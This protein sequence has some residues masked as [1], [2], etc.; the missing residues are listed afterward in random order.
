MTLLSITDLSAGYG[1]VSVLHGV[2]LSVPAGRVIALVGANGAGKSTLLRTISGQIRATSG[3]IEYRGQVINDLK[4]DKIVA[5]GLVQ[6]PE[7]RRLFPS[8]TVLENLLVGASAPAAKLECAASLEK[9]FAM[10]P[11]LRERRGQTAGTLSGGEQQMVAIGRALMAKPELLLIDE[12]SLGL[13]PVV[14]TEIFDKIAD[15]ASSG[16]TIVVVEQNTALAL[17][18]ASYA[19]VLEHGEIAL[20]GVASD[21][22]QDDRVRK[23]Y[24]GI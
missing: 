5:A 4:P 15:L 13:A 12:I 11:K 19:Y 18:A 8:M 7:G 16:L 6:V 24:L 21:L 9:V 14:V 22:A 23:A 20:H 3:T 1:E 17:E 10:F 2:T